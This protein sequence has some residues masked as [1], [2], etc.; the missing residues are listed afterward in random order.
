MEEGRILN[1]EPRPEDQEF[2]DTLRPR[3]LDEFIGQERLR[4]NFRIFIE[5]AKR[6][7]EPL[8]HILIFGPPGKGDWKC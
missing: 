7:K 3:L 5:A 6:R 1:A 4:E 2:D 8:D